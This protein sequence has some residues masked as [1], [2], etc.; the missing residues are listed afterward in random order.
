M[1]RLL[2]CV[3][4]VGV[5]GCGESDQVEKSEQ[6]EKQQSGQ[7]EEQ[8][9]R[10][11]VNLPPGVRGNHSTQQPQGETPKRPAQETAA[12]TTKQL[13]YKPLYRILT[14]QGLHI[15]TCS[16]EEV[17]T[18]VQLG[19]K[20]ENVLGYVVQH[21]A[22]D[23]IPLVK[24]LHP[25]LRKYWHYTTTERPAE[26]PASVELIQ[27]GWIFR[28]PADDR[29][30]VY[31]LRNLETQ[32]ELFTENTS[33]FRQLLKSG[34][35][36][37]QTEIYVVQRF[38]PLVRN[39]AAAMQRW[40]A[41]TTEPATAPTPLGFQ[42]GYSTSVEP[43]VESLLGEQLFGYT[44]HGYKGI[45]FGER[46]EDLVKKNILQWVHPDNPCVFLDNKLEF[47]GKR[48]IFD[49]DKRLI[50]LSQSYEGKPG[51]YLDAVI[52]MFGK[53]NQEM[54]TTKSSGISDG[55][56]YV[57]VRNTLTYH[58]SDVF[59][60]VAMV[61]TSLP[62]GGITH[63]TV[64]D[65]RWLKSKLNQSA[66]I[67]QQRFE[68]LRYVADLV[69]SKSLTKEGLPGIPHC[70]LVSLEKTA[71]EKEYYGEGIAYHFLDIEK[72]TFNKTAEKL[73]QIPAVVAGVYH[74]GEKELRQFREGDRKQWRISYNFQLNLDD[75]VAGVFHQK[76]YQERYGAREFHTGINAIS[77]TPLSDLLLKMNLLF[78][79]KHFPSK[80]GK[81]QYVL[82]E[83]GPP[84]YEWETK[85][86][87]K[88]ACS[89]GDFVSLTWREKREL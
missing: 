36:D 11:R 58:F 10:F 85:A 75:S 78:A 9:P 83:F 53:T 88:V 86:G 19:N 68:W 70:E 35:E 41:E 30:R 3:L 48:Y 69:E 71:R 7:S 37:M 46:H 73:K 16:E 61:D 52:E 4:L 50:L 84:Y 5:V 20:M 72:N 42:A 66:A 24:Y 59:V 33:E 34:W 65:R 49:S 25:S 6:A 14:K 28:T 77:V 18:H 45:L 29:I 76:K 81:L 27:V 12:Q 82:P 15:F 63:V 31:H 26:I 87:W 67:R 47:K 1:K 74:E 8:D 54:T 80:Y 51:D 62:V 39:P 2:V 17:D 79:Q 56:E 64:A 55:R 60:R 44:E 38:S 23:T 32:E 40:Q 89:Y 13:V 22:N 57:T 43:I 21:E